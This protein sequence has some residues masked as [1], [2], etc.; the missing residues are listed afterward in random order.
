MKTELPLSAGSAP[1]SF[2]SKFGD[3]ISAILHGFD[4]VRLRG[5][6]RELYCPQ[7]M[8]AYLSKQHIL[9]KDFGQLV[10]RTTAALKAATEAFAQK[11]S[12]PVEY[13]ASSQRS[14]EEIAREIA[15]RDGIDEGLIAVLSAVEPCHSYQL[16][17]NRETHQLELRMQTRKCLHFYF[18]FEHPLFGFMHLRLQSWFPF[19]V[20]VCVNGRHWLARQLDKAGIAYT[21]RENAIL[22][23]EDPLKAQALLEEQVQFHWAE[24]LD[25]LLKE[26]HPTSASICAPLGLRYYWSM[27]E[28][29]YAS[30]VLFKRPEDLARIYPS[31]VHHGIRSFGSPDVMRFLGR[32]PPTSTGRVPG[33]FQGE[34]ISD[35]K[36]RP[37]GIR[38]KHSLNGNSIKLYDKQGSVL[39]VETTI[40]HPEEFK[41]YRAPEN[42]PNAE[43][44][45]R[46]LRRSVA[47]TPRRAE[48]SKAANQRYL[49]ALAATTGSVPLSE[50]A[51]TLCQPVRDHSR[52]YRALNPLSEEDARV[53]QAISR[54]EF[55]VRGFRNRDL[56]EL[57]CG[58]K[59]DPKA[60][61]R[62]AAKVTRILR[63]LR[64]H[65][66]VRKLGN[67]HRY[68]LTE[69]G[70]I[71]LTAL[72]AARQADVDKL[73]QLA[74]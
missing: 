6:V 7:V 33:H 21:K 31:L 49:Q 29:E 41:V 39:R 70:R 51:K 5:T 35:L 44:S 4:R 22:W 71:T 25:A 17:G 54:G 40:V 20:D 74:A 43:K 64:A 36:H 14:K 45:W 38:V 46:V 34:I 2:V 27:S 53:F 12:R 24:A 8:E 10:T 59:S 42:N 48:V 55:T 3:Q 72:L 18:Y 11:W 32:K 28:S 73:T 56:R 37:E 50:Q 30:D 60:L 15:Q 57:L 66:L 23:V 67:T 9:F 69:K 26:V 68:V 61:K 52:R 19:R 58:K 62:D 65:R 13:V 1:Q 16:R 47:D 63:L